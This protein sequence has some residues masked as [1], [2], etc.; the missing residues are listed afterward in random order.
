M[1]DKSNVVKAVN[2]LIQSPNYTRLIREI[3]DIIERWDTHPMAY[4]GELTILNALI[5]VGLESR[6]AFENLVSLIDSKRRLLPDIKRIDY[7]RDLMRERRARVN[8]AMELHELSGH[9]LGGAADKK[10]FATDIQAR[11]KK[12]RDE[13]IKGKGKL[14]WKERNAAAQEFWDMIDRQLD[15]NI[16]ALRKKR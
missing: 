12:A 13:F 11:W 10:Q 8:K 2:F 6:T 9:E 7:Q 15:E 16:R 3:T 5:D 4:G 14:S 1:V